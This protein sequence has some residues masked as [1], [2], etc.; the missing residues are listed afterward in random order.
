MCAWD[1]RLSVEAPL[2]VQGFTR[3]FRACSRQP[4]AEP[5]RA[6]RELDRPTHAAERAIKIRR[7]DTGKRQSG[8]EGVGRGR[9]AAVGAKLQLADDR[10]SGRSG[11]GAL[12]GTRPARA[13]ALL[14][15]LA[16]RRMR[17]RRARP[18]RDARGLPDS[19]FARRAATSISGQVRITWG[20][21]G[22]N[23]RA[24]PTASSRPIAGALGDLDGDGRWIWPRGRQRLPTLLRAR[25]HAV[26]REQGTVLGYEDQARW[27]G[28]YQAFGASVSPAPGPR[29]HGVQD[30]LVGDPAWDDAP[31]QR[32]HGPGVARVLQPAGF[33]AHAALRDRQRA[34]RSARGHARNAQQFG[35]SVARWA[36]WTATERSRSPWRTVL[37]RFELG[38]RRQRL[39]AL[40]LRLEPGGL[41]I[42]S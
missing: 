34:G 28:S 42:A 23:L 2:Y 11:C 19:V 21:A 35:S 12:E 3:L 33:E 31:T 1:V 41:R 29:R 6:A 25:L 27:T 20:Q 26:L 18:G 38:S 8:R 7:R 30:L 9:S 16:R 40:A 32:Q 36:T 22:F 4:V 5:A 39:A 14:A 13:V 15:G 24:L 10:R 37:V 17:C